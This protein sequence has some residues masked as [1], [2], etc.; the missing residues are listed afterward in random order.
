MLIN[1]LFLND[2]FIMFGDAAC[3]VILHQNILNVQLTRLRTAEGKGKNGPIHDAVAGHGGAL[4]RR[5]RVRAI[6]QYGTD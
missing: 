3:Q 4:F 5:R 2:L 6:R 1:P